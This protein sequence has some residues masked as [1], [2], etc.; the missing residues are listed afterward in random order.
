M[1]IAIAQ[2]LRVTNGGVEVAY[3]VAHPMEN[4]FVVY[5]LDDKINLLILHGIVVVGSDNQALCI[6]LL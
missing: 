1:V 4:E 5:I 3:C 2:Y 6:E